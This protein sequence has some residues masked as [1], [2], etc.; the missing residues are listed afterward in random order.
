MDLADI[1]RL[2]ALDPGTVRRYKHENRL[3]EPDV[4]VGTG[5]GRRYGWRTEAVHATQRPGRGAR[6][7]PQP[8]AHALEVFM[9]LADI[10]RL[11]ALDPGTVRRYKHE[12]RLPEP[13][14]AVGTGQG[15]RYGWRTEAVHAT[16][17]PG[18]GART[19]LRTPTATS[20]KT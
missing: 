3:P 8:T 6:T 15:R 2:W 13:D 7:D 18:R 12:N 11:W 14:V 5:Q 4:A 10:A 1:A 17:R 16:Q 19:D 9:D 20:A